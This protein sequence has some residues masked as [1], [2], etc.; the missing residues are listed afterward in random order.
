[1]PGV[2]SQPLSP[3]P[4]NVP[5]EIREFAETLRVLFGAL[6]M[7]LNQLAAKLHSDPGTVSRYLSGK[8]IPPPGF[9]DALC[10]AVY[11][12]KGSLITLQVQELLHEQ[13]LIALRVHN[14]ARYEV[15]RLTDLLQAAVQEKRQYD[16]TVAALEEA[17]AS[18][19]DKIYELELEGRQLRSAWA[20]AEGLLEEERQQRE[21]LQQEIDSLYAEVRRFQEQLLSAQQ[22]TAEAEERCHEL[23]ARLDAAGA[24]LPDEDQETGAQRVTAVPPEAPGILLPRPEDLA[25]DGAAATGIL[26]LNA[27]A[28][29]SQRGAAAQSLIMA[30]R[31][32]RVMLADRGFRNTTTVLVPILLGALV[33]ATPDHAGLVQSTPVPGLNVFAIQVVVILVISSVL[34]GTALSIR[35]FIKE[36]DIYERERMA[37]LSAGAYLFSKVIVLS[38][39]S[40]LQ[41]A[42]FVGVGLAGQKVPPSGVVPC[43]GPVEQGEELVA[44]E[45]FRG[46]CR[47]GRGHGGGE[48][49]WRVHGQ[50]D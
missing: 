43:G 8:R 33:R 15:Q 48:I 47:S 23:E 45:L 17:I 19:H 4:D 39:I 26:A 13:F 31:Y 10:K 41:T 22:Q 24:L 46:E 14:P 7:S 12:A 28:P 9:I 38:L 30:R 11:D 44:R 50:V 16:I 42:L 35:E 1:L 21:H 2:S 32:L 6:G 40:V 20:R 37:G 27:P 29:W 3:I 36:R 18:R 5:A 25:S 49:W 34:A